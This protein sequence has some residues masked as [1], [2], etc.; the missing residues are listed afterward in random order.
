MKKF[1]IV[2][3]A[4][5]LTA[6]SAA[7]PA[8]SISPA[9]STSID[10][11][12]ALST[13]PLEGISLLDT[14][15]WQTY[16][17]RSINGTPATIRLPN[18]VSLDENNGMI[19][20]HEE[21][22]GGFLADPRYQEIKVGQIIHL[23]SVMQND[24]N[25]YTRVSG[26]GTVT[27]RYSETQDVNTFLRYDGYIVFIRTGNN[28]DSMSFYHEKSGIAVEFWIDWNALDAGRIMF[29]SIMSTLLRK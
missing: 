18:G 17:I 25:T 13:S 6:C 19:S 5:L 8:S 10:A 28:L 24:E 3:F 14:S 27:Y 4:I 20:T 12:T 26:E 1:A 7:Q 23:D 21:V 22:P 15:Q 11:I 16:V 2:I 29:C 9:S